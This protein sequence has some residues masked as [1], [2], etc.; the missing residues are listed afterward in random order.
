LESEVPDSLQ[1]VT[2]H[3]Y[4]TRS[5]RELLYNA[6]KYSDGQHI[7]LRIEQTEA[8]VHFT[9]E[10][11]GPGLSAESLDKLFKPFNKLDDLS[12]GLGLGL[13]LARSHILSL[14][15]ILEHDDTYHDGCRFIVI[16]PK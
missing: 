13:P 3:L 9:V 8:S 16:M 12:E 5:L 10:D 7:T 15:G 4:L 6:A 2:N 11:T 1:I 14:G